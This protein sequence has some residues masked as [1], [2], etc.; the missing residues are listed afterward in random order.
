[1]AGTSESLQAAQGLSTRPWNSLES[2]EVE[3][4]GVVPE[5]DLA[6]VVSVGTAGHEVQRGRGGPDDP[7]LLQPHIPGIQ[8]GLDHEL[9]LQGGRDAGTW[10]LKPPAQ[11]S[12]PAPGHLLPSRCQPQGYQ[13]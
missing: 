10:Q 6:A 5:E 7:T 13:A 12:R 4:V 3:L 9:K 2:A 11:P 1:M 8:D